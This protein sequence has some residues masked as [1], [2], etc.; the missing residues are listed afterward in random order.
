MGIDQNLHTSSQTFG[1]WTSSYASFDP[2]PSRGYNFCWGLIILTHTKMMLDHARSCFHVHSE[3]NRFPYAHQKRSEGFYHV[4]KLNHFRVCLGL[5][6]K[7]LPIKTPIVSSFCP[8]KAAISWGPQFG[9]RW[10]HQACYAFRRCIPAA[11][12]RSEDDWKSLWQ[13]SQLLFKK[14]RPLKFSPWG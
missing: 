1:R 3:C 2:Y 10:L 11:G 5:S 13:L 14:D 4:S 9:W 7:R 6:E 8:I 12:S